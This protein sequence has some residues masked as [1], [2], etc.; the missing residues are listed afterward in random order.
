MFV[1]TIPVAIAAGSAF[2]CGDKSRRL[3]EGET[4]QYK[5]QLILDHNREISPEQAVLLGQHPARTQGEIDAYFDQ[6][7]DQH[8]REVE[9][10]RADFEASKKAQTK[11][12]SPAR[13]P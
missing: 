6:L 8:A 10:G 5:H 4:L 9:A 3:N 1:L 12:A 2:G 11:A 7:R 13:S